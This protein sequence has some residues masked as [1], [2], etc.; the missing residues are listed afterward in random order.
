[1]RRTYSI[2]RIKRDFGYY[3]PEICDLLGAHKNTVLRWIRNG[4][5]KIDDSKPF[6]IHGSQLR[7]FL[8]NQQ[9]SRK[10][11][12]GPDEFYCFRCR[13]PRRPWNGI[14][15]ITFRSN[16]V[17]NLSGLCEQCECVINK[18]NSVANLPQIAKTF[19]LQ[20][21]HNSR[22]VET[23]HPRVRCYVREVVKR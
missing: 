17:L 18:C 15:D 5:P 9:T 12:C 21:V 10:S 16:K 3:I 23:L 2:S 20:A 6:L 8:A 22:I 19:N 14:V 11:R 1:M 4:L 13:Q 7:G